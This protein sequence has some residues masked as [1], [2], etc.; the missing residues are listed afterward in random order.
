MSEENFVLHNLMESYV[1]NEFAGLKSKNIL[2]CNCDRCS[3]DV[4]ALALNELPARY[5]VSKFGE[6]AG[7]L[8]IENVQYKSDVTMAL[9]KAVEIV[10]KG[11]RH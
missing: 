5:F 2:H 1:K 3:L 8:E 4:I 11:P 10:N 6:I 9:Y 7:R